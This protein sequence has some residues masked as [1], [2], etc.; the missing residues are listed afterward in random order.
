VTVS[1]PIFSG[2]S[3]SVGRPLLYSATEEFL[4]FFGI[5]AFEE[6]PRIA[7]VEEMIAEMEAER[8]LRHPEETEGEEGEVSAENFTDETS[9]EASGDATEFIGEDSTEDLVEVAEAT[10]EAEPITAPE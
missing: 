6:L 1:F 10:E 4:K 5:N 7:E 3:E 9:E 8:R 2:R